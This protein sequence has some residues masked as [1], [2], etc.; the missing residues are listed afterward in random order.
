LGN[1]FLSIFCKKTYLT[2]NNFHFIL[3][4]T[5]LI[6]F[7]EAQMLRINKRAEYG[8]IALKHLLNQ[9]EGKV[10]RAKEIAQVYNIPNEIMAKILQQLVRHGMVYSTQGANGGYTLAKDGNQISLSDIIETLEGP[11]GIVE[12]TAGEECNCIQLPYCNISAPF[13]VIQK[14]FKLFL[15]GV[16]LAD[17]NSDLEI[18]KV[19]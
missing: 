2:K 15:S 5:Y 14:Q 7:N 9:P 8:I 13:S 17:L 10:S 1:D 12:C 19:V 6:V 11:L 4:T 16:S 3:N 18:Q